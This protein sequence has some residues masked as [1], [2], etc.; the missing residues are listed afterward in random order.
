MATPLPH[1]LTDEEHEALGAM[2]HRGKVEANESKIARKEGHPI[3]D[4]AKLIEHLKSDNA[5]FRELCFSNQEALMR[6]H[7]KIELLEDELRE[8]ESL[9]RSLSSITESFL[10]NIEAMKA[11]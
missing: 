1:G 11:K 4:D 7:R 5:T 2:I 10:K 8:K 3:M 6:A 9:L